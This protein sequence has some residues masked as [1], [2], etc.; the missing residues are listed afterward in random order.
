[1]HARKCGQVADL[2]GRLT[3]RH[4][5][6]KLIVERL[7]LLRRA[8]RNPTTKSSRSEQI[9]LLRLDGLAGWLAFG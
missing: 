9:A 7:G 8:A 1:M 5:P 2:V 6:V 4:D 3:R